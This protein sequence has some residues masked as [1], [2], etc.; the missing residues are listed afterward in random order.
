MVAAADAGRRATHPTTQV[1]TREDWLGMAT[2]M[3]IENQGGPV[4]GVLGTPPGPTV[5]L[6]AVMQHG[7][8]KAGDPHAAHRAAPD[9]MTRIADSLSRGVSDS[10]A[11]RQLVD[12]LFR[13]L[14]DAE[15]QRRVAADSALRR[16]LADLLPL[17]PEEHRDHYRMLIRMPPSSAL[18]QEERG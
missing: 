1:T 2:A 10:T 14:D 3:G 12:A 15:I 4:T 18:H 7:A 11:R 9:S 16:T 6:G 17:I 8:P 13:L 5:Q